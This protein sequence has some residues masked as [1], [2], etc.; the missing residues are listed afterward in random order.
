MVKYKVSV[1]PKKA[2]LILQQ[3]TGKKNKKNL[4]LKI[5]KSL[6]KFRLKWGGKR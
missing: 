2:L 6:G 3:G 4:K 1:H 5:F